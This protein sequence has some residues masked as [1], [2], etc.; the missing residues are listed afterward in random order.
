MYLKWNDDE[1]VYLI[2][3]GLEPARKVLY[4]KYGHLIYKFYADHDLQ[5][6]Y[7]YADFLQEGLLVLEIA[8]NKYAIYEEVKFYTYFF[9]CLRNRYRKLSSKKNI[10]FHD[11]IQLYEADCFPAPIKMSPWIEKY[12]KKFTPV[13]RGLYQYCLLGGGKLSA[14]CR[15]NNLN[16]YKTYRIYQKMRLDLEKILTNR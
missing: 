14:Y 4:E 8:I 2:R 6:L 7:T 3:E 1:L 16:Y 9:N 5:Y 10:A 15:Q 12:I 11:K 13:E